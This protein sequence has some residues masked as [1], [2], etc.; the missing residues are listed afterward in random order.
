M[1]VEK[2][3]QATDLEPKDIMSMMSD[4]EIQSQYLATSLDHLTENLCNLLHSV[5]SWYCR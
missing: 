4:L 5:S 3:L 1:N 2:A